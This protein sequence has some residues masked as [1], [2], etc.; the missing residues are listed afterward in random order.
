MGR[1]RSCA[2]SETLHVLDPLK[3]KL[4]SKPRQ[5]ASWLWEMYFAA[6]GLTYDSFFLHGETKQADGN[7]CLTI[8]TV[9]ARHILD[10]LS[11]EEEG[12]EKEK[13]KDTTLSSF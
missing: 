11:S 6:Q 12:K 1:K 2:F 4:W 8:G 10:H 13:K 3:M 9:K 5:C 7:S